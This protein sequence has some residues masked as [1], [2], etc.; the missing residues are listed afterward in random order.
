MPRR[1]RAG[2]SEVTIAQH[3]SSRAQ[4]PFRTE[5]LLRRVRVGELGLESGSV[6]PGVEMA[7]ETWGQ[8]APDGSNAVL[9]EHALTG[10][11]H[12][13][14]GRV[15][16]DA[17][18]FDRVSAEAPGWW[19]GL[20]GP[21]KA[22][23][24]DRWY[25]VA[26]N[27]LGGCYG[28][29]GPSSIIPDGHTHAGLPWGSDFPTVT[30]RD[31]V[32]AEALVADALGVAQWRMVIGG[33]MGGARAL[34]W[35][36]TLPERVAACAVIAAT[37]VASA[38]QLAWGQAQN[39]AIRQD[40]D[41]RGGDYYDGVIPSAGLGLARRIAHTTYRAAPD[42]NRRFGHDAQPGEDPLSPRTGY[43]RGR[44][45]IESYLDHQAA[46][47][48]GRFDA[49]SYLALNEAL[50]GHDIGRGRGGVERALAATRCDWLV[51]S[52]DSDRLYLPTESEALCRALPGEVPHLSIRSGAGHDGFLIEHEQIGQMV[53]R[54]VLAD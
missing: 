7:Y 47:L 46:K 42:L 41:F 8:L 37:A 11:T 26:I 10:D 6:L 12:V 35:A 43:R 1:P 21:G 49:N 19:E 32:A 34:E 40:P 25:V 3:A 36:V 53:A 9:V 5:G 2:L 29:T 31:S 52:V 33:S 28:S 22:I 48:V 23:D 13:A 20:I 24:T 38:E 17:S 45:A 51:S 16:G 4:Q 39:L 44:Y 27:M 14:R 15:G 18:A 30:I 50:M 54:T